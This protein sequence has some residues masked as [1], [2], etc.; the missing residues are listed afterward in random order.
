MPWMR[1]LARRLFTFSS[2]LSLTLCVAACV[3]WVRSA[4]HITS[5]ILWRAPERSGERPWVISSAGGGLHLSIQLYVGR[6]YPEPPKRRV[7]DMSVP[8]RLSG[9]VFGRPDA[10]FAGFAYQREQPYGYNPGQPRLWRVPYWFVVTLAALA[11]TARA[12]QA[13]S[14]HRARQRQVDHGLCRACGY[15]LCASPDRCP[16]CGAAAGRSQ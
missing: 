12:G 3:P 13:W 9:D 11:P 7:F 14:R 5:L 8:R 1:H 6:P 16:E 15:D 10:S 2:A 4:Y